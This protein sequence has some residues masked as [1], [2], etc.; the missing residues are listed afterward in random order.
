M[1]ADMAEL[2][3]KEEG[4]YVVCVADNDWQGRRASSDD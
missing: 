1:I 4:A 3:L 2:T